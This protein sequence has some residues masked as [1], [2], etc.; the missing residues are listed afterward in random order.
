MTI[1]YSLPSIIDKTLRALALGIGSI[2]DDR[3]SIPDPSLKLLFLVQILRAR[4]LNLSLAFWLGCIAGVW[5]M[6]AFPEIDLALSRSL[7]TPGVG[8]SLKGTA[9]EQAL[10][11]SVPLLTLV[12]NVGLIGL[13]WLNRRSGRRWLGLGGRQLAFLLALLILIPGLLVNQTLKA[14]WGRVRPID[15]ADFGGG[16]HF[17]P[18]FV[19]SEQGGR[20]F[21]SG[22]V[23]AAAYLMVVAATLAGRRSLWFQL[24]LLYTLAVGSARIAAG[25]HFFS[26]VLTSIAL[27]WL[28]QGLLRAIFLIHWSD[29]QH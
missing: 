22:H 1:P 10:Y 4:W 26:D 14:H 27:V 18:A 16:Q 13:W 23:A 3:R 17:T 21:S 8:F 12:V 24:A 15:I 7:Y 28:G 11:G 2:R 20:S 9:W 29:E 25:G 6:R 19:V 5:V